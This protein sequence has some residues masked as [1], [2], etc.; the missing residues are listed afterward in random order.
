MQKDHR[1]YEH[2][3]ETKTHVIKVLEVEEQRK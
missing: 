3:P 1:I 2:N